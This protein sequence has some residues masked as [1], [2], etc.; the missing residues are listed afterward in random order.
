M[1]E[2]RRP[3]RRGRGT[4]PNSNPAV[5]SDGEDNPYREATPAVENDGEPVSREAVAD[6]PPRASHVVEDSPARN[7]R[8]PEAAPSQ[9]PAAASA[10]VER[11]RPEGGFAPQQGGGNPR[12]GQGQNGR[13]GRRNRGR[14]RRDPGQAPAERAP[15][16]AGGPP[17]AQV[18]LVAT[19]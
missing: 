16:A 17:P 4:R 19:G 15:M 13:R 12:D 2:R 7:G 1:N 11:V 8:E 5:E 3:P 10:P 9:L 6:A 18:A 14:G